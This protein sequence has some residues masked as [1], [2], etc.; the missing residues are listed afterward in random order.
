[1]IYYLTF[2][3]TDASFAI[4]NPYLQVVLNNL[5]YG[6]KSVG[7]FLAVF[8]GFGVLGP[9][10][11]GYVASKKKMYKQLA[12]LSILGSCVFF[13]S[14]IYVNS[15]IIVIIIL[16][17]LGFFLRSV[18]P[19]VDSIANIAVRGNSS[20]YTRIRAT[21]TVGFVLVSGF[22]SLI[23]RPDVNSNKS[24]VFY[25]IV[26]AA[27]TIVIMFF[28]PKEEKV[29]LPNIKTKDKKDTKWFNNGLIIGFVLIGLSQFSM[30]A[31]MSFLSL[32][33]IN[34]VGYNNLTTLS[35]IGASAEFFAMIYSGYLL[36]NK[37]VKPTQLLILGFFAITVR[38]FIYAY[39]PSVEFLL[40]AQTLHSLAFG[41]LHVATIMFIN[42]HVRSD[43]RGLG[44]S[45]YFAL[46]KSLPTV[47]GSSI[48][49]VIVANF[50]FKSL[51]ISYGL[52]SLFAALMAFVFYK[53]LNEDFVS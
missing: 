31:V 21:G 48:G 29:I 12:I 52:V 47:I 4:I 39:L 44:I 19:L 38:L 16:I 1:M 36:Q 25:F 23:K 30:S 9:L 28:I 37:K 20:K 40:L 34:V 2:F 24:I 3:F 15:Y 22:L 26:L 17:L 18:E 14:L 43:K 8:E 35:L 50:G 27:I 45:L 10:V 42:Q 51:F 13:Y 46:S 6:I 5:G 33:S 11:I 32:Y 49:G 7:I 53:Q 41:A